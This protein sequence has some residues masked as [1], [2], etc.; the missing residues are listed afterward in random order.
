MKPDD[1]PPV[2]LSG[3]HVLIAEDDAANRLLLKIAFEKAGAKASFADHGEEAWQR[4]T[5]DSF[6]LVLS[7]LRMPRLDG[8]GLL[9]RAKQDPKTA[10]LPFILMTATVTTEDQTKAQELGCHEML[11]K[12]ISLKELMKITAQAIGSEA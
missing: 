3:K 2:D 10:D 7:D 8:M 12:P 1:S 6:D 9:E 5:E 4:L 11:S